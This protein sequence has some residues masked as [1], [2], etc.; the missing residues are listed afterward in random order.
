MVL[1][2]HL[3][4]HCCVQVNVYVR[5][6]MSV[7]HAM[8][9][10]HVGV[11][12][13]S[14]FTHHVTVFLTVASFHLLHLGLA[15]MVVL[16][17]VFVVFGGMM[18]VFVI[19][20]VILVVVIFVFHVISFVH[21]VVHWPMIMRVVVI[22]TGV[23]MVVVIVVMAVNVVII[24]MV[25][26]IHQ[27]TVAMDMHVHG[28]AEHVDLLPEGRDVLLQI[29]H[30]RQKIDIQVIRYI[31]CRHLPASRVSFAGSSLSTN[32]KPVTTTSI[33]SAVDIS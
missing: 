22:M 31:N 32:K 6:V 2:L 8:P 20:F 9:P 10:V 27:V 25:S 33:T 12:A 21:L 17:A 18:R 1:H 13:V 14:T 15:V 30:C 7:V 3:F 16:C 5:P 11:V 26:V 4:L 19:V 23:L 28:L 24:V 29:L